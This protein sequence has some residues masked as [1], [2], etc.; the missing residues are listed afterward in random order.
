MSS[1]TR[2]FKQNLLENNKTPTETSNLKIAPKLFFCYF[3]VNDT[4]NWQTDIDIEFLVQKYMRILDDILCIKYFFMPI[5][6]NHTSMPHES[7]G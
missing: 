3:C 4:W 7:K 2:N 6:N 1:I 5:Y